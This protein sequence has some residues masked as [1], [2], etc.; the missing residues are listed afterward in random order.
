MNNLRSSYNSSK[1][2]SLFLDYDGTLTGFMKNPGDA[3]PDEELHKLLHQLE[4]DERNTITI[5]SGRDR[6]SLENWFNGH[7]INLIVEHGVW[8]KKHQKEW[9][10]LANVN[11]SW[12]P[13]IRPI[14]ESFVDR[15]PGS[16]IEEKTIHWFGT[17]GKQNQNKVNLE[18]M[19]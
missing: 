2:R 9:R 19:N 12:K 4:E 5:I 14:L 3:H 1:K 6:N 13:G 18:L 10:M 17:F 15:T 8:I 16:F 11:N 7:R